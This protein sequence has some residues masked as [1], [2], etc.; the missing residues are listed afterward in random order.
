MFKIKRNIM[1][2]MAFLFAMSIHPFAQETPKPSEFCGAVFIPANASKLD[3]NKRGVFLVE[4]KPGDVIREEGYVSNGCDVPHSFEIVFNESKNGNGYIVQNSTPQGEN[5]RMTWKHTLPKT[6]TLNA[7]ERKKIAFELL[8]PKDAGE[9]DHLF[10]V[11]TR[12]INPDA[13][14]TETAQ[15]KEGIGTFQTEIKT[16]RLVPFTIIHPNTKPIQPQL[17]II[18]EFEFIAD[19]IAR[20]DPV[21]KTKYRIIR[22]LANGFNDNE[23][24]TIIPEIT[25]SLKKGESV[26]RNW[27]LNDFKVLP[28]KP[29][30]LEFQ[31]LIPD[32]STIGVGEYTLENNINSQIP[33]RIIEEKQQQEIN[34]ALTLAPAEKID[35]GF[36]GYKLWKTWHWVLGVGLILMWIVVIWFVVRLVKNQRRL[37]EQ[38]QKQTSET[39]ENPTDMR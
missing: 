39:E 11:G 2:L 16:E 21:T 3:P 34:D 35:P 18:K 25:F 29:F 22:V 23:R 26:I 17:I 14:R 36:L 24:I 37:Q 10:Y 31:L 6:F 28:K 32:G 7:K 19:I 30:Q 8:I 15:L 9:M 12:P 1:L 13:I 5:I 27:I 4:G 33:K 38:L 20:E